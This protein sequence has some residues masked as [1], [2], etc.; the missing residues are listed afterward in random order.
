VTERTREIGLRK[1]IGA[2]RRDILLQF[3]IEA[4]VL[5]LLGGTLG[6]VFG[7][8]GSWLIG[9]TLGWQVAI[10]IQSI[11]LAFLFAAGVGVFFGIYPARR[12]AALDPIEALRYE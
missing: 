9:N 7:V 5:S 3:L 12:A 2:K 11:M 4:V 10:S 6:I 1:A 8:I